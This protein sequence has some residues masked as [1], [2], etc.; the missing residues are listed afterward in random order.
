MS[1]RKLTWMEER[2]FDAET[3]EVLAE[4]ETHADGIVHYG[5]RVFSSMSAAKRAAERDHAEVQP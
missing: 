5:L 3:G 4:L 1:A 2:L